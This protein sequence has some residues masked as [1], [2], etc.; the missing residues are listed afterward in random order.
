MLCTGPSH[1]IQDVV[2]GPFPAV[3]SIVTNLLGPILVR[4]EDA[5]MLRKARSISD[6]ID[7]IRVVDA[8]LINRVG[9]D[10]DGERQIAAEFSL[11]SIMFSRNQKRDTAGSL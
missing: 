5:D 8:V 6:L 2:N 7:W 11:P 1:R 10:G 4:S 9:P 3:H